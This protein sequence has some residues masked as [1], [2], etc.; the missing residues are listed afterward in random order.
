MVCH[1][2]FLGGHS[3]QRKDFRCQSS[4]GAPDATVDAPWTHPYTI[5]KTGKEVKMPSGYDEMT[6]RAKANYV[7]GMADERARRALLR[8]V[9]ERQGFSG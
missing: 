9:M 1:Q 7:G 6:D 8:H 4:G 3:E 2:N 5:W